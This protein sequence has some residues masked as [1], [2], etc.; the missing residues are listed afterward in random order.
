MQ[1]VFC[2][3]D[4]AGDGEHT[5][6]ILCSEQAEDGNMPCPSHWWRHLGKCA[7]SP[8]PAG[9]EYDAGCV[10]APT[11]MSSRERWKFPVQPPNT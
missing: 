7:P 1:C 3:R 8:R 4:S 9:E 5:P 2:V 6:L 11:R 10:L